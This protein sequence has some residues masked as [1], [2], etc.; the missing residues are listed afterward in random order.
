MKKRNGN[1][2]KNT[3]RGFSYIE[4]VIGLTILLIGILA[5][6]SALS[7]NLIR[8]YEAEKRILAK[9]YGLSTIES[10]TSARDI[11]RPGVIDNWNSVRN[12]DA[13]NPGGIFVTDFQPIREDSGWDGVAGTIDDACAA[14]NPCDIPGRTIN[15]SR[16]VPDFQ[17]RIVITDID[18]PDR[19]SPPNPIMQRRI[20]V[21]VR[22]NVN[23]AVRVE[24]V[25]TLLTNY[26]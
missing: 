14:P 17:R 20:E 4:V 10:I 21:T 11:A 2:N 24:T 5:G 25:S 1:H 16:I 13:D 18:D 19:P 7:A 26:E 23:Q 12:I 8:S 6:V 15:D 22:F 3:Q 9:Q